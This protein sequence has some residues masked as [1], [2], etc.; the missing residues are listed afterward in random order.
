MFIFSFFRKIFLLFLISAFSGIIFSTWLDQTKK[1]TSNTSSGYGSLIA[2]GPSSY[3]RH[4]VQ[5]QE[6]W[7]Q[8]RPFFVNF[9]KEF[10]NIVYVGWYSTKSEFTYPFNLLIKKSDDEKIDN[11]SEQELQQL[12]SFYITDVKI[13]DLENALTDA[14]TKSG[15]SERVKYIEVFKKYVDSNILTNLLNSQN[16]YLTINYGDFW[17]QNILKGIKNQQTSLTSVAKEII[18]FLLANI[19][20]QEI[21]ETLDQHIP[22]SIVLWKELQPYFKNTK[23]DSSLVI[24]QRNFFPVWSLYE[25]KNERN[26]F[27]LK[28]STK[29]QLWRLAKF[30]IT[31]NALITVLNAIKTKA[32]KQETIKKNKPKPRHRSWYCRS[33]TCPCRCWRFC[34]LILK[35]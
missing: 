24:V 12:F 35:N 23:T 7:N 17:I 8:L 22:Q 4:L 31:S 28:P 21:E 18:L 9:K 26:Y 11:W 32:S 13:A 34:L 10:G 19:T 15:Q 25:D 14:R 20:P 2:V 30:K 16:P 1:T 27:A 5:L 6:T 29:S 3:D 33:S